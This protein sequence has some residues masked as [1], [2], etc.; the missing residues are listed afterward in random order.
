M[1]PESSY[2]FS[3]AQISDWSLIHLFVFHLKHF[4]VLQKLEKKSCLSIAVWGYSETCLAIVTIPGP[5]LGIQ[6][7]VFSLVK[8]NDNMHSIGTL[9]VLVVSGKCSF[10]CI[11]TSSTFHCITTSST[12]TSALLISNFIEDWKY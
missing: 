1:L 11:T 9:Q 4:T 2:L 10:H 3:S 8:V 6:E 7:V 5:G 12:L